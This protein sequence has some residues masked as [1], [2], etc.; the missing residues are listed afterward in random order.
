MMWFDMIMSALPAG[1]ISTI[2]TPVTVDSTTGSGWQPSV[3]RFSDSQALVLYK[4]LETSDSR[5]HTYAVMLG[6]S[7]TTVSV[8]TKVEVINSSS[9]DGDNTSCCVLSSTKAM[10]ANYRNASVLN[11]S[12]STIT[13]GD[14]ETLYASGSPTYP[15]L[16]S[17]DSTHALVVYNTGTSG[18]ASVLTVSGNS[19]STGSATVF[20][21][22]TTPIPTECKSISSTQ[23]LIKYGY[24][25]TGNK[26]QVL[27]VS[28]TTVT[29]NTA[30]TITNAV[31]GTDT[32]GTMVLDSTS[33]RVVYKQSGAGIYYRNITI[34][35]SS[36][37]EGSEIT[38]QSSS[39]FNQSITA[40]NL[41][42][43]I[44]ICVYDGNSGSD[45]YVQTMSPVA[46]VNSNTYVS[47]HAVTVPM[48]CKLSSS[49]AV[50]VYK[51]SSSNFITAVAVSVVS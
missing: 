44:G 8:G 23:A 18:A 29:A 20:E 25:S 7:G 21:G 5:Y 36:L 15:N 9:L 41:G 51:D 19:F 3:A 46:P 35:G 16:I 12:G 2:G 27:G 32:V 45:N 38:I 26:L 37:S 48:I 33:A 30:M 6:V 22:G 34:S 14:P 31:Y 10:Q 42:S 49:L 4:Q 40:D 50:I 1:L 17:V 13:L 11:I 28:G 43:G 24:S 47:G 39:S